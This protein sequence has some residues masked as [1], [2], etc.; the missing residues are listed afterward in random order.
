MGFS[1]LFRDARQRD[2]YWVEDAAVSFTVQL[3][4]L[5]KKRGIS[6]VKLA[7]RLGVSPPYV[8]RILKGRENLTIA[9]MVKL[10][11][12]VGVK[13]EVSLEEVDEGTAKGTE[14]HRD[15]REAVVHAPAAKSVKVPVQSPRRRRTRRDG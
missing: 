13:L 15:V 8:A 1:D 4:E 9:S 12:A 6:Q 3:Y 2:E 11:R 10:A 14:M 5:M 7:E